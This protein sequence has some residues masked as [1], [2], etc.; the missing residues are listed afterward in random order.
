[1]EEFRSLEEN[2]RSRRRVRHSNEVGEECVE[3]AE[4]HS[5]RSGGGGREGGELVEVDAWRIVDELLVFVPC[6]CYYQR[7]HA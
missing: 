5:A 6:N 4:T 3:R 2:G 1:M 7:Q